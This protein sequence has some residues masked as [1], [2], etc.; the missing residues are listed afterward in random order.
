MSVRSNANNKYDIRKNEKPLSWPQR[1]FHYRY[2]TCHN[3]SLE[4]IGPLPKNQ[5]IG[6]PRHVL[7]IWDRHE[8]HYFAFIFFLHHCIQPKQ[9]AI[10][11]TIGK[12]TCIHQAQNSILYALV[13]SALIDS[14]NESSPATIIT[15]TNASFLSTCKKIW[16][17][18]LMYNQIAFGRYLSFCP[19]F[20]ML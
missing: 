13:N 8:P 12:P 16:I 15:W 20:N 1:S 7:K 19:G 5:T 4:K 3:R 10:I 9:Q 11:L 17:R 18:Y 14:I 2:Q 6:P